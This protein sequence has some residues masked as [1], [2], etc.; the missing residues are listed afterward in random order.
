M[1][2]PRYWQYPADA[3]GPTGAIA[4]IDGALTKGLSRRH[5][6]GWYKLE[7]DQR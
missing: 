3:R 6:G 1:I 7:I 5:Q 4:H 2:S